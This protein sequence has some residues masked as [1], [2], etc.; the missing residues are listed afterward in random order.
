V[1]EILNY[2]EEH[3]ELFTAIGA[4]W[5]MIGGAVIWIIIRIIRVFWMRK[6]LAVDPLGP[7]KEN[8]IGP[9]DRRAEE[10]FKKYQAAL[11]QGNLD[12]A[13][14][15]LI[16]AVERDAAHFAPFPFRTYKPERILGAGGFGVVFQCTDP[17]LG[18]P[19]VVKAYRQS[20]MGRS[21]SEV[22]NEATVLDKL[23]H[24]AIIH[25]K[26][27]NYADSHNTRPYM[28]MDYFDGQ[29]LDNYVHSVG[30]LSPAE[31]LGVV[32]P[33]AEALKKAH[34]NKIWH[35]DVKP[36]N[37]LVKPEASKWRVKLI[38]FGLAERPESFEGKAGT[39]GPGSKTTADKN[40]AGTMG[41]AAPEQMGKSPK[42]I[43]PYTD[44]YGFG[45]TC[46][47]ALFGDPE[48]DY[49]EKKSLSE[50]W[51]TFLEKC[52]TRGDNRL[53]D[54]VAV[55][56]ELRRLAGPVEPPVK[57]K[58]GGEPEPPMTGP[59]LRSLWDRLTER[60][61]PVA[62]GVGMQLHPDCDD[63]PRYY[64]GKRGSPREICFD[65][66]G[67]LDEKTEQ[68][69]FTVIYLLHCPDSTPG[70]GSQFSMR[71]MA[72][73]DG[74]Q[75]RE[76]VRNLILEEVLP[77]SR[78]LKKLGSKWESIW[79]GES[80]V[81]QDLGERD[82]DAMAKLVID[83]VRRTYPVLAEVFANG[84]LVNPP[85]VGPVGPRKRFWVIAPCRYDVTDPDAFE[86][87]WQYN[88]KQGVISIGWWQ[89]GDVSAL[90]EDGL[91]KHIADTYDGYEGGGATNLARMFHKFFHDVKPG[92]TIL[93]RRGRKAIAGIGTV[94]RAAYYDP[95]KQN[96]AT[97]NEEGNGFRNHIDVEW[98]ET[99][100]DKLFDPIVFAMQ[101]FYEIPEDKFLALMEGADRAVVR[102]T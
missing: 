81:L 87:V 65:C 68:L 96:P 8:P 100:R 38:D 34:D 33:V 3:S 22:F 52:T 79:T 98:A 43:G 25:L 56:E 78:T 15:A 37:I 92:D 72:W 47:F 18:T 30:P 74:P 61:E 13:L 48:P 57:I 32:F 66:A 35:R 91:L 54:F 85:P 83:A 45:R 102:E 16:L 9:P 4:I 23:D 27:C 6:P 99:P 11:Q 77:P 44:V 51:R 63:Y 39:D 10:N 70:R 29:S 89:M 82:L 73:C 46:Y 94:K 50:P 7:E 97:C 90:D 20:V 80:Y 1:S 49:E 64:P 17:L 36:E 69:G 41:Y 84:D 93:A 101:T 12:E 53:P 86:K 14:K 26:G 31:L 42:P 62:N 5:A 21:I 19:V 71:L 76:Y 60:V 95:N 75:A 67:E 59:S 40:T 88:L 24:P 2:L 55:L 28:V 58:T